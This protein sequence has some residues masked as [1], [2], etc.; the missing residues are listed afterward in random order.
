MKLDHIGIA[1]RSIEE[2]LK[3]WRDI[4]N[5]QVEAIEEV[6]EQKVRVA[7]LKVG[8]VTIELLEPLTDNS[9]VAKYIAKRGEGI[10]HIGF[11]VA[12]LENKIEE[13]KKHNLRMTDDTPRKG[14]HGS[15]IA[16]IHPVSTGG[17]LIELTEKEN[18]KKEV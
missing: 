15:R 1:V 17:I 2:R 14:A 10:H 5:V 11:E 18:K 7:I 4:F 6:T 12:D 9:P 16:F 13:F 3:L 8:E